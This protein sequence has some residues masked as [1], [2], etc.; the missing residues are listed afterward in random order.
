[1]CSLNSK[2][3]QII[4]K[5]LLQKI[6]THFKQNTY[7]LPINKQGFSNRVDEIL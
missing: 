5:N 1:M 6:K 3:N 7:Y 2:I 4:K